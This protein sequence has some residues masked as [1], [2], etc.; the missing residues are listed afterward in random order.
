MYV[1][2][3]IKHHNFEIKNRKREKSYLTRR[4][5]KEKIRETEK[6]TLNVSLSDSIDFRKFSVVKER[7]AGEAKILFERGKEEMKRGAKFQM[8]FVCI[9]VW[10]D[11]SMN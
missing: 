8:H 7:G 2:A 11:F 9:I 10:N 6:L 5:Q 4:R 1:L 3:P